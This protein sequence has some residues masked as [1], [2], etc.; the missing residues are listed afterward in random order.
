MKHSLNILAHG[1]LCVCERES[2][3]V[4]VCVCVCVSEIA[5]VCPCVLVSNLVT[6]H[7]LGGLNSIQLMPIF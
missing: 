7:V 6:K 5:Y 1:N 4:C 2:V 3:C